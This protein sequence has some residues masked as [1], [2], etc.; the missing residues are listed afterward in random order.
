MLPED[1]RAKFI[2]TYAD[3]FRLGREGRVTV[4]YVI[5]DLGLEEAEFA[6]SRGSF[7]GEEVVGLYREALRNYVERFGMP[8][9]WPETQPQG[10]VD[11]LVSMIMAG[12]GE[13]V[14]AER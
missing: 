13:G 12:R 3:A 11:V 4:G 14:L 2:S 7:W 6:R 9:P 1:Q 8:E 5:L 10:T